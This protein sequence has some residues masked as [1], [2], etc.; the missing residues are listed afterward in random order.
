MADE[1][2][3]YHHHESKTDEPCEAPA[4]TEEYA[5]V[6]SSD[7]GLFDFLGKEEEEKKSRFNLP[8]HAQFSYDLKMLHRKV[9]R[10]KKKKK[11]K[12]LKDKIK[13]KLSGE[14]KEEEKVDE[15]KY[16][17]TAVPIEKC[18]DAPAH[19]EPEDKKGLLE[20]IK[21]KLPAARDR[22]SGGRSAHHAA[23]CATTPEAEGKEKKGFLEKIKEKIP[24]YHPKSDEEKLKEKEKEGAYH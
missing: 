14:K 6:E 8:D 20:Q 19:H 23:D 5:A 3:N 15:V 11:K 2:K 13:D 10:R 9:E 16:E 12:G 4:K 1:V 22:G 18:D 21:E 24:G 7:R 17:D